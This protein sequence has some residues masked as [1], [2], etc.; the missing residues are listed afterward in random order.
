MFIDN[1]SINFW[2]TSSL[3]PPTGALPMDTAG[4]LPSQ[5]PYTVSP[6]YNSFPPDSGNLD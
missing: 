4:G 5:T 3:T 2:V 1:K 6:S